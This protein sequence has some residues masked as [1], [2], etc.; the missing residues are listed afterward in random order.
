MVDLLGGCL[1]LFCFPSRQGADPMAYYAANREQM[2][3]FPSR[4]GAD[5]IRWSDRAHPISFVSLADKVLIQLYEIA[6]R[7]VQSF[8]S[9]ADKVLIQ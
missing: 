5:P 3:C 7:G 8:V 2:F 4:Q 6:R 9:L 1:G